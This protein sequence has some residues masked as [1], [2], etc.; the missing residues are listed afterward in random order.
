[1]NRITALFARKKDKVLNVYFTAG[2]P[3]LED[4]CK[5]IQHLDRLDVDLVELGMP[6]SDPL[7]DGPTIQQSS[8]KALKNG[9]TLDFLFHQIQEVRKVSEVPIIMMG[10][11]NQMIQ[12]GER[13]FLETAKKAGVDG[14]IIPDL[15]MDIYESD[16]KEH[17][18][19]LDL[20]MS[21][22]VTPETSDE[23]IKKADRLSSG[24]LYVVSKSSITGSSGQIS[25][26][27]KAYFMHLNSLGLQ[28]PKLIG[29]GIHNQAT[30]ETACSYAN[31]A[32]IGSAFIRA[33]EAEGVLQDRIERFINTI[34]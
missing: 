17:F 15:P 23:R 16:Y 27:Q 26:R 33:L 30:Y 6:Y 12:Y 28:S 4:T 21:F 1:M 13:R 34:R 19:Q 25:D 11:F 32:I 9:M 22:L 5:I 10:Y 2:H 14:M 8:E 24:F 29:F 3:K 7:A 31:G 18:D 20:N